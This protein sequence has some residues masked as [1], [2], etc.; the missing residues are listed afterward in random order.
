MVRYIARYVL[1]MKS[2]KEKADLFNRGPVVCFAV[3]W[4]ERLDREIIL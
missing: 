4:G 3:T 2:S 1:L